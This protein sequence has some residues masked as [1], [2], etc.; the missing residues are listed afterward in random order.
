[1]RHNRRFRSAQHDTIVAQ[2]VSAGKAARMMGAEAARTARAHRAT[3]RHVTRF[4]CMGGFVPSPKRGLENS[5]G[6]FSQHSRAGLRLSRPPGWRVPRPSLGPQR[7][8]ILRSLG[9]KLLLLGRGFSMTRYR[10]PQPSKTGLTGPPALHHFAF[11][12]AT[13]SVPI[14][15]GGFL[16]AA[17]PYNTCAAGTAQDSTWIC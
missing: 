9:W 3:Q 16:W 8:P 4:D 17:T 10:N 14:D 5:N 12:T 1:M 6:T 2:H 13:S 15:T 7:A 11:G